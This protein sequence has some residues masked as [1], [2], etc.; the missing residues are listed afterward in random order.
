MHFTTT[1]REAEM[2]TFALLYSYPTSD[3]YYRGQRGVR[4]EAVSERDALER[5]KR[6]AGGYP[7]CPGATIV[8]CKEL[9][10]A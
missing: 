10:A 2:K 3:R 6:G 9:A 4:V 5:V 7:A 8:R 1:N